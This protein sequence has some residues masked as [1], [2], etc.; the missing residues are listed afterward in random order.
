[1][2]IKQQY[3]AKLAEYR[4]VMGKGVWRIAWGFFF[5]TVG[6]LP[7]MYV[8]IFVVQRAG[9]WQHTVFHSPGLMYLAA[10]LNL[11]IVVYFIFRLYRKNVELD[12][13]KQ[14]L[15]KELRE[16]KTQLP[17]VPAPAQA[18]KPEPDWDRC[19]DDR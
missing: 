9:G 16:L 11:G 4:E 13:V 5:A 15:L 1:M 2:T 12:L 10:P 18:D 3:D 7:M 8:F 19:R 17:D 14:A 6:L